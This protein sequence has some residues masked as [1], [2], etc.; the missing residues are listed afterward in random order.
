MNR[1]PLPDFH[2]DAWSNGRAMNDGS[3]FSAAES[4]LWVGRQ[5][6]LIRIRITRQEEV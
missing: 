4:V 2:I 6:F 3:S 5:F 1:C